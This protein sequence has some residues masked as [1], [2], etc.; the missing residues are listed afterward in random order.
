[1]TRLLRIRPLAA[2]LLLAAGTGSAA[3]ADLVEAYQ[4]ARDSDPQ[5]AAVEA[6]RLAQAEGVV[7]SRANLLPPGQ[8]LR[9]PAAIRRNPCTN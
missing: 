3:A 6:Q 9:L 8:E 1:M 2:A 4:L 7:Q 5:L